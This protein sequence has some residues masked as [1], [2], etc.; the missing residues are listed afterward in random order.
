[1]VEEKL[2][3]ITTRVP[4]KVIDYVEEIAEMDSLDKA[5]IYRRLLLKAIAQDRVE[6][7]VEIYT[8]D[9]A[10]L[11]KAAELAGMPASLFAEELARRNIRRGL[12]IE[13]LQ[14]G[15]QNLQNYL[16]KTGKKTTESQ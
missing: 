16:D 6:R 5:A 4:Q 12:G 2:R 1:M 15:V 13:A 3:V 7:A 14:E 8:R 10:T 11:L 9:E